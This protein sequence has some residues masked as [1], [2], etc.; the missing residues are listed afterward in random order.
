MELCDGIVNIS[1]EILL[2]KEVL[3]ALLGREMCLKWAGNLNM[4][5]YK[6]YLSARYDPSI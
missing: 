5:R 3:E 2:M 1:I 4:I 6:A